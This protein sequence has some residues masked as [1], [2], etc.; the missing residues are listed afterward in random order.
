MIIVKGQ[1]LPYIY[2]GQNMNDNEFLLNR[3]LKEE[4][5]V[6]IERGLYKDRG[7]PC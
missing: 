3:P 6:N 4:I 7:G 2:V 1:F 5:G